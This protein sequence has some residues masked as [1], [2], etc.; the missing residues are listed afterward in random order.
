MKSLS[1]QRRHTLCGIFNVL[2]ENKPYPESRERLSTMI[3]E[4]G[5][6]FVQGNL[7]LLQ[8]QAQRA[9]GLRPQGTTAF[10]TAF[11]V[12]ANAR[13]R[14]QEQ[15][16]SLH[17]NDFADACAG[18]EHEAQEDVIAPTIATGA[19]NAFE[20]CLDLGEFEMLDFTMNC[21]PFEWDSQDSLGQ[22]QVL[23]RMGPDVSK[24]AM[25]SAEAYVSSTGLI[26]PLS[27]QMLQKGE[28][29]FG[30]QLLQRQFT[31]VALLARDKLQKQLET[32]AVAVQGVGTHRPL[33]R[34]IIRQEPV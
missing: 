26:L 12:K 27:L 4:D 8:M 22:D 10:L 1:S 9:G 28:D 3:P 11:A 30:R 5:A 14:I 25:D 20:D 23:R 21:C 34:Q 29:S 2:F 32:V 31:R 33:T 19:V 13:R 7:E 17:A 6:C 24:E 15:I 16:A 18:I